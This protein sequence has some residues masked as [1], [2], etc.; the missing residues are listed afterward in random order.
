MS[1]INIINNEEIT[2]VEGVGGLF[3]CEESWIMQSRRNQEILDK[4]IATIKNESNDTECL[5]TEL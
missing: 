1:V 5:R 2:L 3:L 4:E